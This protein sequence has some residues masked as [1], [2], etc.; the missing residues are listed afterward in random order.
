MA[1]VDNVGG[2]AQVFL[3]FYF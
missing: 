2:L 3:M 1:D